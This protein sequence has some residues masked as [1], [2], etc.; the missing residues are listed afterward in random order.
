MSLVCDL[1]LSGGV[2]Y[3][4]KGTKTKEILR[5]FVNKINMGD[6]LDKELLYK[7]LCQREDLLSTAVGNGIAIPHPSK[8]LLTNA[9]DE[10]IYIGYLDTPIQYGQSDI[11][12]VYVLFLLLS[13]TSQSHLK[14]ISQLAFLFQKQEFRAILERKADSKEIIDTIKKYM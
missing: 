9:V 5:D 4:L 10:R 12:A 8:P 11:R 1:I 2:S 3:N 13:S 14:S 6:I 7:E